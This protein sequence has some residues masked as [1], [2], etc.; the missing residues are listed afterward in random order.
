MSKK[1]FSPLLVLLLPLIGVIL[2]DLDW[3]IFD[4]LIMGLLILF[5]SIAINLILNHLN[6]SKLRLILVLMLVILF[7]LIWAELAV[8]VFGTPFAGT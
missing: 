4:F 8:G 5:F 6:S 1:V 3:N 2:F 7:L